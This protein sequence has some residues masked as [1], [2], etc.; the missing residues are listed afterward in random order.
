[1]KLSFPVV[2]R[3]GLERRM[4]D[5]LI[6]WRNSRRAGPKTIYLHIGAHKTGTSVI[7]SMLKRESRRLRW[8][9]FYYDRTFYTLGKRLARESP[10]CATER[11]RLRRE[12]DARLRSRTERGIIGS[13]EGFFGNL[14][15]SYANIG[16][17]AED[18]RRIL[19]DYDVRIFA[20]VRRQDAFVESVYH[21]Y[22]KSGGTLR[23]E[24]FT[25]SHD[26][27]AYRWNDLLG[28]YV[29]VFGRSN[30]S[31]C[32][33]EDVFRNEQEVLARVFDPL[34]AIGFRTRRRPGI[35]NPGL[36]PVGLE[37]AI[38]CNDVLSAEEQRVLRGF[39]QKFF[40][41]R[42]GEPFLLFTQQQRLELLE[43]YS[44]SNRKCFEEFLSDSADV[45]Q[46]LPGRREA[47]MREVQSG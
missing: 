15:K 33:Y 27:R 42:P 35:V 38:R 4:L 30:V 3:E 5:P 45:A 36:S 22:V 11:E 6:D 2:S 44:E 28:V 23:F 19:G 37:V 24:Q 7:Q 21:Q 12:F 10:L 9:G 20:C 31:V 46:Y 8:H 1:M 18:L 41:R 39:L 25:E 40:Y 34:A 26:I 17:V 16:V 43:Y 14:F 47:S 32:R 29:D 13:A